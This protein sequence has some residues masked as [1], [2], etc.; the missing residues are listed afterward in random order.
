VKAPALNSPAA[1][2]WA[3]TP[4]TVTVNNGAGGSGQMVTGIGILTLLTIANGSDSNP[5]FGTLMDGDGA[6]GNTL[7]V[8]G[9]AAGAGYPIPCGVA[10]VY[11]TTGLYLSVATGSI[12]V[13]ATYIPLFQPL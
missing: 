11:F 1:S 4:R 9:G 10:G 7:A 3:T 6:N 13:T 12:Y 2:D 8:I 5:M